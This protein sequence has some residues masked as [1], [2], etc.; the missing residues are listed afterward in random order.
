M[1]ICD[2]CQKV[3]EDKRQKCPVC[4]DILRTIPMP[5]VKPRKEMP[6]EETDE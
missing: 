3:Y 2:K 4:G 1:K 5:V 6:K